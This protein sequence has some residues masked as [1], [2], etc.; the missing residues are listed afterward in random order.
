MQLGDE[1]IE[2]LVDS[3][4]V[5]GNELIDYHEFVMGM[6]EDKQLLT[7]AKLHAAFEY[8][9]KDK[10]GS[11]DLGKSDFNYLESTLSRDH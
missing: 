8:F 4:D 2:E 7:E 9:D 3:M 5:D 11:I 10:N 6:K 1:D